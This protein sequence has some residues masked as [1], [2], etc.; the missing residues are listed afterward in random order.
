MA[1]VPP[2]R[3]F[4]LLCAATALFALQTTGCGA[5]IP[6]RFVLEH[7]IGDYAY[8]RYQE[9]LDV[10]FPVSGD[11]AVG[12]TAFY[13]RRHGR[14][15]VFATAFVTVYRHARSLTAEVHD[16]LLQLGT[17]H[18]HVDEVSGNEVWH[19]DGGGDRWLMW[20]SGNH[21]VKLGGPDGHPVPKR[22]AEAY[23]GLYPSDL[24]A[25]GRARAG[26]PSAG[27]V[28]SE[29]AQQ[30]SSPEPPMP[31]DLSQGASR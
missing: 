14:A 21:L 1:L 4:R 10:E 31:S 23:L 6:R 8:R 27:P 7:D 24:D 26:T 30:P 9:V 13:V 16:E 17:Y 19:L 25:H 11:E 2:G 22:I 29:Q 3:F 15:I 5:S 28:H 20:V 18:V 12:H